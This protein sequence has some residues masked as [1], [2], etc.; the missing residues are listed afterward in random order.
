MARPATIY[1]LSSGHGRAG[2]A[3]IRVSGPAAGQAL[4]RLAGVLPKPRYA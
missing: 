1:A 2:V 3:V 4:E